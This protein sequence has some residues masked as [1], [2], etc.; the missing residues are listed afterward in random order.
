VRFGKGT[1]IKYARCPQGGKWLQSH[2]VL[3]APGKA[4]CSGAEQDV[5]AEPAPSGEGREQN[6]ARNEEGGHGKGGIC[7]LLNL[8]AA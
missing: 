4:R 1:L 3:K 2:E 7:A 8:H 5:G 6:Q